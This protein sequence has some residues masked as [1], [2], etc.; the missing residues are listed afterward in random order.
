MSH[1]K[2]FEALNNCLED[3]KYC[4]L[5]MGVVM[6]L[7]AGDFRQTLPVV[8]RE[9]RANEIAACIKSSYWWPQIEKVSLAINML[10]HLKGYRTAK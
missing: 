7:L 2:G 3:L 6:V 9:T 4:N 5:L 1:K 10:V 8:P